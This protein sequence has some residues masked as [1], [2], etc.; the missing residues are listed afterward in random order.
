M[1]F[2]KDVF[3]HCD[4][5][6]ID[7]LAAAKQIANKIGPAE[8]EL[9]LQILVKQ[10][11]NYTDIRNEDEGLIIFILIQFLERELLFGQLKQLF[12]INTIPFIGFG[13]L[14]NAIMIMAGEYIDQ[15]LGTF[16]CISTMAAAA[17]GNIISG[18][19]LFLK[20]FKNLMIKILLNFNSIIFKMWLVWDL[21]IMWK[22]KNT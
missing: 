13:F 18:L 1:K 5:I 9:L 19:F 4:H 14:D 15:S 6:R 21:P 11:P 7:D 10:S 3:Q 16:F 8:R 22:V 12:T 20:M 17:L 2:F